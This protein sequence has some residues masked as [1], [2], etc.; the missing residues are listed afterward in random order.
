MQR[1]NLAPK[2][3]LLVVLTLI[4]W[5]A[6]LTAVDVVAA[7]PTA[8][9]NEP[10]KASA[11]PR[12]EPVDPA[13]EAKFQQ[14]KA[15]LPAAQQAWEEKLEKCLGSFYLPGYKRAKATGSVTAWDYVQ[16]DPKL[17]RVLLIG[18]SISRG[19]TLAVRKQLAGKANVHRAPE[20]CG[21]TA[22]GLKKLDIWLDDGRWD[23]IHFN[24]GIHDQ[25]TPPDEYRQR[26]EQIVARLQKTGAR[27][28]WGST[29][30][31]S[32]SVKGVS[33]ASLVE[34]NAIAAEVMQ[35]HKIPID[36]LYNL[37]LPDLAKYQNPTDC[38]FGGEGYDRLGAKVAESIAAE[39][40]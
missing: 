33:N 5:A 39:L 15:G 9:S 31:V 12:V 18:D 23:V 32:E 35:K 17:P 10:T 25:R 29:T 3:L 8:A 40:K 14:W 36:D 37:I 20:N 1:D 13:T 34:R 22:N 4:G 21:G 28:I 26:L 7:Q 19:Y 6:W 24:F 11:K 27:L 2:P 16:D 38:H 30:P